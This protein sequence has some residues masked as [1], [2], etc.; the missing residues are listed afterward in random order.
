MVVIAEVLELMSRAKETQ[1]RMQQ[2]HKTL[3]E[4]V[5]KLDAVGIKAEKVLRYEKD[6]T[7]IEPL[8][9]QRK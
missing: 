2:Q 9:L 6:V 3:D 1:Q 4:I 8:V 5:E 7:R